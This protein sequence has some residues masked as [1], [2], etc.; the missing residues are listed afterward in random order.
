[1]LLYAGFATIYRLSHRVY[2]R[3]R[4]VH[5]HHGNPRKHSTGQRMEAF[6]HSSLYLGPSGVVVLDELQR[7]GYDQYGL[8]YLRRRSDGDCPLDLPTSQVGRQREENLD[9]CVEC[10]QWARLAVSL[11]A[12]HHCGGDD[13]AVIL[14]LEAGARC[15]MGQHV[16]K[17]RGVQL[18]I[19]LDLRGSQRRTEARECLL[20][21]A[22]SAH[23]KLPSEPFYPP[24]VFRPN[25]GQGRAEHGKIV[26]SPTDC[27]REAVNQHQCYR[28]HDREGQMC[29]AQVPRGS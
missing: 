28:I 18:V 11:E 16:Q 23:Q 8:A 17:P 14:L 1:M 25:G 12:N 26:S 10:G 19:H 15:A 6:D 29:H 13:V 22:D 9:I 7:P 2:R 3:I 21:D 5:G 27:L 24:P 20:Q 4:D